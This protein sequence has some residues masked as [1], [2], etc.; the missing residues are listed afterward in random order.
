MKERSKGRELKQLP[1]KQSNHANA[2][3]SVARGDGHAEGERWWIKFGDL[4]LGKSIG[5][6]SFGEVYAAR[7][8]GTVHHTPYNIHCTT[9][10]IHHTPHTTHHTTYTI[11]HTLY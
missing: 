7:Y 8:Q 6:G 2:R 9:Y 1:I 3:S 11:Q 4:Q 10:N 5:K